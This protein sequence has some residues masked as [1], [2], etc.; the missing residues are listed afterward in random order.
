MRK[1]TAVAVPV[2]LLAAA[3]QSRPQAKPNLV[4]VT[5]RNVMYHFTPRIAVH[6]YTLSGSLRPTG[7]N[8]FPIFDDA[9]S[10]VLHVDAADMALTTQAMSNILNDHVFAS[11]DAPLKGISITTSGNILKIRGKLHSKGDIPFEEEGSL[12]LTP[13]GEIRVHSNRV[14]AAHL[15]VKGLMDLLGVNIS[16]LISTSKVHGVRADKDDLLINPGEI[17]PLPK[18]EGRLTSLELRGNTIAEHFGGRVPRLAPG[19]YMI[20]RGGRLRFG[21]LTMD[22]TDMVLLDMDAQDPFDFYL[23]HYKEQLVAGYTKTTPAFGLRV[24]MRDYDKL[25]KKR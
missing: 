22:D 7:Q 23:S 9:R 24:L 1:L 19:N 13:E 11:P 2:L 14:R 3:A 18:I 21:K 6:I 20:Y 25:G 8:P 5:M 17:L 4:A 10:F 12:S 15:P 16:D